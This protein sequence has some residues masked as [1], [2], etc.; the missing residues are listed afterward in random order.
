MNLSELKQ[1]SGASRFASIFGK[2]TI[3]NNNT[4]YTDIINITESLL[5]HNYGVIHGGY[6]GGTMQAVSDT[7]HDYITRHQLSPCLNI[8]IP[9]KQHD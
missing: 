5:Q 2:S 9:Q 8:G 1:K 3:A 7:A 6:S 4:L